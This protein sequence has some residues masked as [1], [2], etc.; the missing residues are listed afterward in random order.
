[1][2]IEYHTANPKKDKAADCIYLTTDR[3]CRN[4]KSLNYL[5]KCFVASCCPLRVKDNSP[6]KASEKSSNN[7]YLESYKKPQIKM[8]QCSLPPKCDIY[9]KKYGRGEFVEYNKEKMTIS[10]QFEGKIVRF[11]Y[12]NAIL[13]EY[14]I[15]PDD[16]YKR[17]LDDVLNAVKG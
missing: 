3:I 11:Q 8:I 9:S 2:H 15:L 17:V 10:V 7:K 4:K 12:P 16:A 13:D 5:A 14:L 1:M 6:E